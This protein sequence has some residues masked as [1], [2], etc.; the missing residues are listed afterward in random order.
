MT[1]RRAAIVAP[2]RTPVGTFGGALRDV[3]V[4]DLAATAIRAVLERTGLDPGL[5]EDVVFAQSYANAE[6]PCLGR[7]AAL[8]ADLPVS[9]PGL[10]IDR[11]CGGGLQAIITAA[12]MVQTGAAD[13]VLAGGAESMS[14]AEHYTTAVR[15]GARS[16]NQVLYDRLDRGRERSQ[17]E[18]RFGK[19]SGMI[20]TA[21]NL[22]ARYGIT[23]DEADAYAARSHQRAAAAWAAGRFD[24][25]VVPVQVPQR[26]GEP[27][28][29]SRDEGVR[30]DSTPETLA[31]LRTIMP[32][33]TVTAGNASQQNDAAA[34]CLVVAEDRL[35]ALGLEPLGYLV[36]WAAA[37]VRARRHGH[38]AGAGRGQALRPHRPGLRRDRP[39][40]AERGVRRPGPRGAGRL[41]VERAGQ[42]QR[43][44]IRHLARPPDRRDRSADARDRP[45]RAA[46]ARTVATCW[47]PCASAAA[48]ASRPSSRPPERTPPN[49]YGRDL[50]PRRSPHEQDVSCTITAMNP[51]SGVIGEAWQMYKAHAKHLLAIAFVIYL[52]AAIISAVLGL[53][54]R[55]GLYLALLVSILALFLLQAT[56]V[57]AVQDVRDG[58][59]DLSISETVN[60]A[61]PY[62][63][64]VIG[65]GFLA[66]IAI[67]I[68]FVLI[69]V[70]GLILI[71]LWAVFVPVIVIEGSGA[72]ASFGR[73]REL[74][75]GRAWHVFGTLVLV[76]IILFVFDILLGVIFSFV[77][78]A[79]RSGLA[80]VISGTLV[81]PF[82]ALVVT[83]MYYRLSST[84]VPA[85]GGPYGGY[86]QQPPQG[87]GYQ[88]QPP[89]GG[90]YG[91]YQQ[92]QDQGYGGYQQ[93]QDQGY[94]GYQQQPP[95][96]GGYGSQPPQDSGYGNYPPTQAGYQP[97]PAQGGGYGADQPTQVPGGYGSQPSQGPQD[98]G[99]GGYQ[100]PPQQGGSGYVS[101]E[102]P[103]RQA[104][105]YIPPQDDDSQGREQ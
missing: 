31:K 5:I 3:P 82:I 71:T 10:Q 37:G 6:T 41:G 67:G 103:T 80:S 44:R 2:M 7:W 81:A 18:W 96:G 21:E 55:T 8:H 34:A 60:Q 20:E 56:L 1:T 77:P 25:E 35:A 85:G 15:W 97:P 69:I 28:T 94:G 27:V 70:P 13:V 33:G 16:G 49:H 36:G 98:Q 47:R 62:L 63:P 42:A 79:V 100:Q 68:G 86:Q 74:V 26:R 45:A 59:A 40:G 53:L 24:D 14:N 57:K 54:G 43:Q 52:I 23:R 66:A 38:R 104:P 78:Y 51:L 92:P 58:R 101:Q 32:G 93:P 29:V 83:L 12:M 65:A 11:R 48:R 72:L 99:Y 9:V 105:R 4:E 89:Q 22:A 73:S 19:I 46:P 76:W 75:R 84:M 88:Q 102:P 90:G 50:G 30:P 17:P 61:T 64:R 91:G 95:Q 39:G 87:G